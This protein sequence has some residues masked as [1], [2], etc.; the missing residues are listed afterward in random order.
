M[1]KKNVIKFLGN[2]WTLDALNTAYKEKKCE[3]KSKYKIPWL[4]NLY[5]PKFK[6]SYC[7]NNF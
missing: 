4:T 6:E 7:L 2:N 1:D 5:P 3:R